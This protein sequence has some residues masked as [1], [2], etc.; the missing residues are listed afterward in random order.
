M[1]TDL[2][3]PKEIQIDSVASFLLGKFLLLIDT[4]YVDRIK[5]VQRKHI[6]DHLKAIDLTLIKVSA[7]LLLF[8]EWNDFRITDK[9]TL[10]LQTVCST[11]YFISF[12]TCDITIK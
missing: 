4:F 3:L 12:I 10:I 9:L 2:L 7:L 6:K 11:L 5:A 8:F 1:F